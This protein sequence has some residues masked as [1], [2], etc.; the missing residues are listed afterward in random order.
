MSTGQVIGG[1]SPL[2]H[3]APVP[4]YLDRWLER[5]PVVW[6]AAGHPAAVFS[7][8]YDELVRLT[9]APPIDVA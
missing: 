6:A 4:T 5:P 3:P 7:T 8:S 9:G 1:V 2:G